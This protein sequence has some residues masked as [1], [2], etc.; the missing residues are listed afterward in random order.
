MENLDLASEISTKEIY[1]LKNNKK[2]KLI[3]PKLQTKILLL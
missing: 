3:F 2:K 1:C